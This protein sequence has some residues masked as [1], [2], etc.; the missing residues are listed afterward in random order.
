[1]INEGI[2]SAMF[3]SVECIVTSYSVIRTNPFYTYSSHFSNLIKFTEVR[4]K[5]EA[6]LHLYILADEHDVFTSAKT[7]YTERK[8]YTELPAKFNFIRPLQISLANTN[9]PILP[10]TN[11]YLSFQR[12]SDDF[13]LLGTSATSGSGSSAVIAEYTINILKGTLYLK[14]L[15]FAQISCGASWTVESL[16]WIL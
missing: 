11:I 16:M 14:K 10:E 6:S 15:F 5:S 7:G 4:K 13:V 8:K 9:S 2:G 3:Q 12:S 1:V